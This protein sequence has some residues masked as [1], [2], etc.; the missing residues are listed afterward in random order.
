MDLNNYYNAGYILIKLCDRASYIN[1]NIIPNE[2]ILSASDCVCKSYPNFILTKPKKDQKSY[3]KE[4]DLDDE[5][6]Q[7][8]IKWLTEKSKSGMVTYDGIFS[9]IDDAKMFKDLFLSQVTDIQLIGLNL[10]KK[11]FGIFIESIH[12]EAGVIDQLKHKN[13]VDPNGLILG[14]EI[15]GSEGG[16]N[17]HSYL[18][19]SLEEDYAEKFNFQVNQYGLI[20]SLEESDTFAKYSNDNQL[21]EPVIWL[22]WL[23]IKY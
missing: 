6:F 20:T 17:F 21:G 4:L 15:L 16:S 12:F 11:S 14:H 19:N 8:M 18:C 9:N 13:P 3:K 2:K 5:K 7:Y 10:P 22:S 1:S 23:L